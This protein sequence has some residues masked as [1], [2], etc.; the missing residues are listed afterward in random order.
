[1]K[2]REPDF[3]NMLKVLRRERPDRPVLYE[4]FMNDPVYEKI[5]GR[6][7]DGDDL[8]SIARFRVDAFRRMGYDYATVKPSSFYFPTGEHE[9]KASVSLNDTAIIVD[10][11]TF[12]SYPW[13]DPDG[14]DYSTLEKIR[15][16]MPDGM[17]IHIMCP[18]GVLEDVMTLVGYENMC[19]MV[20]DDPDLLQRIFDEI[21]WRLVRFYENVLQYDTVG[22]ISCNDDWGFN[23]QT[24]LSLED[25]RRYV[26]PWHRKIV[27][28]VHA[29]GRPILLHSC[30]Y[31]KDVIDDIVELGYDA[32]HSYE[33]VIM[34]VEEA[35]EAWHDRLAILGGMDVNFVCTRTPEEIRARVRAMLERTEERGGY[36]L[37]TGNSVPDYVPME[38]YVAM[39]SE[40]I[41][42]DPLK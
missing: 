10:E 24:F 9:M 15:P 23:T 12:E 22:F 11:K 31:M 33:D 13:P 27:E 38:N 4:L 1:M 39:V 8:L 35:Y 36:A 18:G 2:R 41:G 29:A 40:A 7:P 19:M 26:F 16:Y 25:M 3:T 6:K 30:G 21:G 20:Y 32:K 17:K 37:G 42:Y 28:T 34:P 14:C 5:N